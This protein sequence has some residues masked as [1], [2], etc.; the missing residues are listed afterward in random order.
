MDK[1]APLSL[2]KMTAL[3]SVLFH[4]ASIRSAGI[5]P[6]QRRVAALAAQ[7]S[8][9]PL[10]APASSRLSAGAAFSRRAFG[11]G[12]FMKHPGC[13][14]APGGCWR[15]ASAASQARGGLPAAPAS[16]RPIAESP[17]QHRYR[18]NVS[19][20]TSLRASNH[21]KKANAALGSLRGHC[22]AEIARP[23]FKHRLAI[24]SEN[25]EHYPQLSPILKG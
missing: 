8:K 14:K 1:A 17:R 21:K 25:R 5:L 22:S 4:H 2:Q 19:L 20:K 23:P 12:C 7:E 16:C 10:V 3:C 11:Q 9:R 15:A 18:E 6:A 13:N 24:M